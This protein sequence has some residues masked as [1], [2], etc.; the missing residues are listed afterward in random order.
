M[1]DS[2]VSRLESKVN[3]VTIKVKCI[4]CKRMVIAPVNTP[5]YYCIFVSGKI[6]K[7]SDASVERVCLGFAN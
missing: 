5:G 6:M 3:A 1:T 2:K 7:M 4:N